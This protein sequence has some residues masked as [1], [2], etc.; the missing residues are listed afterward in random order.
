[1][2][3]PLNSHNG[4]S[5][6]RRKP[7]GLFG[8]VD[9]AIG[10]AHGAQDA[11]TLRPGCGDRRRRVVLTQNAAQKG[12]NP[13]TLRHA[14][15]QDGF[16]QVHQIVRVVCFAFLTGSYPLFRHVEKAFEL[17]HDYQ[18]RLSLW[19]SDVSRLPN[20][21][22]QPLEGSASFGIGRALLESLQELPPIGCLD[23]A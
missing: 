5:I 9:Q 1:M 8:D 14:V 6:T 10:E 11:G 16:D 19:R 23:T 17:G 12:V 15:L 7:L 4:H 18:C 13:A 22:I 2:F 20:P 3:V 21:L